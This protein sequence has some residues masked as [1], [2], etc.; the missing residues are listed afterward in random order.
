[1][2]EGDA[3]WTRPV[4][5]PD[6][7]SRLAGLPRAETNR[8]RAALDEIA[9][10]GDERDEWDGVERFYRCRAIAARALMP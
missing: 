7:A 3:G 6:P 10:M 1:M 9:S 8:L 5:P 2:R 4:A